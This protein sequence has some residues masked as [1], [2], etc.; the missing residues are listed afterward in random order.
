MKARRGERVMADN[1]IIG[2]GRI[3]TLMEAA[4]LLGT[5]YPDRPAF[6][7]VA[8]YRIAPDVWATVRTESDA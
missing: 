5:T 1:E 2:Q 4:Q 6:G 3:I 8:Q 7:H